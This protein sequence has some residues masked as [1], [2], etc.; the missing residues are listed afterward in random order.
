[1]WMGLTFTFDFE[2]VRCLYDIL[3]SVDDAPEE[4][5]EMLDDLKCQ[6]ARCLVFCKE[7]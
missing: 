2:Q 1:M 5:F 7:D 4:Q 3:D 6:F